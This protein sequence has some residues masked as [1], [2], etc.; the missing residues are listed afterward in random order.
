MV[1]MALSSDDSQG[2]ERGVRERERGID[3]GRKREEQV[4]RVVVKFM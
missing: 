4:Q 2:N 1:A 3:G